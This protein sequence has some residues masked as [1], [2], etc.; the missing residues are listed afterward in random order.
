MALHDI[1]ER[2]YIIN[3]PERS[4]RRQ[5]MMKELKG[6]GSDLIPGKVEFFPAVKPND[7]YQFPSRGTLGCY[8]SHLSILKKAR[9]GNLANVLMIEDDLAISKRFKHISDELSECLEQVEWDL[10]FLGFFPYHGLTLR[11]YYESDS[12]AA[13]TSRHFTLKSTPKPTQGTHFYAV[14]Q[15]IYDKLI[16]FLEDLLEQRLSKSSFKEDEELGKL[17]GAY[18]D[19]AYFFSEVNIQMLSPLSCVLT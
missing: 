17:D 2:A 11:D 10:I 16:A 13:Y 14:N 5:E 9:E 7:Y 12:Q 6:I 3:L 15:K 1:F 8:L 19:T 18:L 4:D